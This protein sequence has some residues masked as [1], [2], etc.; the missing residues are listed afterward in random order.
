MEHEKK[1]EPSGN[2]SCRTPAKKSEHLIIS[3]HVPKTAGTSFGHSLKDH[4]GNSLVL[5]YGER[6]F[7][8]P[9]IFRNQNALQAAI[10]NVQKDFTGIRCIHGHFL[11]V[12]YLLLCSLREVSFV[13]WM[14]HPVDR[15][16]SDYFH[17]LRNYSTD[18]PPFQSRV[19]TEKWSLGKYCLCEELRNVYHQFFWGFPL[20][21]FDFIGIT[22]HYQADFFYF[23]NRY[24][25]PDIRIYRENVTNKNPG[26]PLLDDSLRKEI[27]QFHQKDMD[28]Y[29]RAI[30]MRN[31]RMDGSLQ[32]QA[33]PKENITSKK[34][35]IMESL[36]KMISK[37]Q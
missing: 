13:T 3:V 5:K 21:Y 4:F 29:H 32:N 23:C 37:F 33:E 30:E 34:K 26:I 8:T 18:A 2:H 7:N 16:I 24:L 17:T 19:L 12:Q 28:L 27:E 15:L 9:R 36:F 25:S 20:E 11:P 14:R 22:G 10:D 31:R 35:L 1:Y 6:L